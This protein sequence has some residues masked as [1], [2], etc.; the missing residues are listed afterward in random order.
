MR[1]PASFGLA[2]DAAQQASKAGVA[3]ANRVD[4]FDDRRRCAPTA[5]TDVHR[6]T[7]G[8][9]R[10]EE[11]GGRVHGAQPGKGGVIVFATEQAAQ[12][13]FGNLDEV[14]DGDHAREDGVV[15][16]IHDDAEIGIIA[17]PHALRFEAFGERH[18]APRERL[19]RQTDA[20]EMHPT[21]RLLPAGR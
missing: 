6:R 9:A 11:S 19:A 4:H 10:V 1:I 13:F 12:I 8:A 21:R 14:G 20:A 3:G 17:D 18:E 15:A 2:H 5:I 16:L 7:F